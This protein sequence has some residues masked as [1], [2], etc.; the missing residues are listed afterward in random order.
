MS[1]RMRRVA[2][3]SGPA[4]A[5]QSMPAPMTSLAKTTSVASKAR[6]QSRRDSISPFRRLRSIRAPSSYMS[7]TSLNPM[8][9]ANSS[10]GYAGPRHSLRPRARISLSA[11][12]SGSQQQSDRARVGPRY[13]TCGSSAVPSRAPRRRSRSACNAA[14]VRRRRALPRFGPAWLLER[15]EVVLG[16]GLPS[17]IQRVYDF[18][19]WVIASRITR[20]S[21]NSPMTTPSAHS[22]QPRISDMRASWSMRSTAPQYRRGRDLARTRISPMIQNQLKSPTFHLLRHPSI[23]S[24]PHFLKKKRSNAR[25]HF[26]VARSD[27]LRTGASR[28]NLVTRFEADETPSERRRKRVNRR[29]RNA[30]QPSSW[31]RSARSNEVAG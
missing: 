12:R 18:M 25:R 15:R 3:S 13:S 16:H 6:V 7:S 31:S 26:P 29:P 14:P 9:R 22:P 20:Y 10:V 21:S 27:A 24:R 11:L 30:R 5:S 8:A 17:S 2:M 28:V 4:A 19:P 1:R 23:P